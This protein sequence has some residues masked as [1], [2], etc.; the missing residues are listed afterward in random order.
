MSFFLID[1]ESLAFQTHFRSILSL[2]FDLQFHFTVQRINDFITTQYSSIKVYFHVYVQV[3]AQTLEYRV[4]GNDE[5]DIQVPGRTS[6]HTFSSVTFQFNHLPV[7]HTCGNGN[8]YLFTID[9]Q[10]LFMRLSSITK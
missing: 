5:S 4:F 6:V 7:G 9:S 10:Y 2:R 1:R 8:T 3:I